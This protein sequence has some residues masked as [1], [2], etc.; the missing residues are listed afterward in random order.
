MRFLLKW[1]RP[2]RP[3]GVGLHPMRSVEL[4]LSPAQTFGRSIHGIEQI[5]GGIV[6]DSD[7]ARGKIEATFGLINSE[8]I[9]VTV[10]PLDGGR[11]RVTI[12]SRRGVS[13]QPPAGSQYIDALLDYVSARVGP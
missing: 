8:R 3:P 13:G 10:E 5:L 2:E 1:L 12:E 9:S 11:S 7:R 4:D 6:R